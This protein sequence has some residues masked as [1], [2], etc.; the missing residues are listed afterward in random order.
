MLRLKGVSKSYRKQRRVVEAL[1][2][3]DL[4]VEGGSLVV[5]RGPSGCGKTTLLLSAGGLMAPDS[6]SVEIGGESIYGLS[7]GERAA[8]R[9]RSVGFVFQQFHLIPYLSVME[10]LMVPVL[11]GGGVGRGEAR[12][13]AEELLEQFGMGGRM[14]HLPEELSTGERQ[15]CALARAAMNKPRLLLAD[16]PTGNLDSENA[17][18]VLEALRQYAAGGGGVLVVSHDSRVAVAG[19]RVIEMAAGEL[20]GSSVG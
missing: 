2:G 14:D 9:A 20:I 8:L 15:R 13:R 6:G 19:E 12:K 5:L 17:A 7:A 10:N 18:V 11:A 3:V 1:R 4:V 16:E